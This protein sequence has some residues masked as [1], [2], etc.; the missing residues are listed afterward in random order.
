MWLLQ[1]LPADGKQEEKVP[2]IVKSGSSEGEAQILTRLDIRSQGPPR[3]LCAH[4]VLSRE[5]QHKFASFWLL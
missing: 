4:T 1:G 3:E 5:C 2:H